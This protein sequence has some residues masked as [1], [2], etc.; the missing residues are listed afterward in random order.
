MIPV[1]I[2]AVKI[3]EH[4]V[5]LR[6]VLLSF[7]RGEMITAEVVYSH[8]TF[9][10]ASKRGPREFVGEQADAALKPLT[11]Q[12]LEEAGIDTARL[13]EVLA[14]IERKLFTLRP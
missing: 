4:A 7:E 9:Q 6:R 1:P 12:E 10:A 11:L 14:E 3:T 2:P 5:A 13:Q 8:L